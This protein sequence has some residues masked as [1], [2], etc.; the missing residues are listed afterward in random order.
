MQNISSKL[1]F[2]ENVANR[3]EGAVFIWMRPWFLTDEVDL[4]R[5]YRLNNVVNDMYQ[6]MSGI[7]QKFQG[8]F[9]IW[10]TCKTLICYSVFYCFT[11]GKLW[12]QDSFHNLDGSYAYQKKTAWKLMMDFLMLWDRCLFLNSRNLY[13]D[14][15]VLIDW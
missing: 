9:S 11:G 10:K 3:Y 8:I 5:M 1:I 14:K 13:F 12:F 4:S 15:T 2:D 7:K 6:R